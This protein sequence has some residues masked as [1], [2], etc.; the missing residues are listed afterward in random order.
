MRPDAPIGACVIE[1]GLDVRAKTAERSLISRHRARVI[2]EENIE[3]L[4]RCSLERVA[5]ERCREAACCKALTVDQV[6]EC[7]G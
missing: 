7:I 4:V 3:R 6:A 2:N 5:C 1:R